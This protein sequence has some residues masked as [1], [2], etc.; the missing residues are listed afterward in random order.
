MGDNKSNPYYMKSDDENKDDSAIQPTT[1]EEQE[2][3]ITLLLESSM[4]IGS[5]YRLLWSTMIW[6]RCIC[7][8]TRLTWMI[9]MVMLGVLIQKQRLVFKWHIFD[10][11][12]II[13]WFITPSFN[14]IHRSS[15][16]SLQWRTS[17]STK[18]HPRISVSFLNPYQNVSKPCCSEIRTRKVWI[19]SS[20]TSKGYHVW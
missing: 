12:C 8:L 10:W 4:Q 2:G 19:I 1:T 16:N 3:I 14:S 17:P 7:T 11:F 13:D 6:V 20:G 15:W 18:L 9:L 5:S